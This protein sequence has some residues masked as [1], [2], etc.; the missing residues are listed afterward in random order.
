[1]SILVEQTLNE[2]QSAGGINTAKPLVSTST[3]TFAA[4]VN[5][6]SATINGG[7][8]VTGAL[9]V[10][11][12]ATVTGNLA[13]TGNETVGG[14]LTVTG[15]ATLIGAPILGATGSAGY[16]T[17]GTSGPQLISGTLAPP[18]NPTGITAAKG[19]IFIN[20]TGTGVTNRL[21]INID[22]ATAWTFL[23]TSGA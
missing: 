19:S 6:G 7:L 13:V 8:T 10:N 16:T 5:N 17:L 12:S 15:V 11:A 20:L 22:G 21:Y 1:M 14:A 3:G 23:A 4:I 9:T 2:I 18:A